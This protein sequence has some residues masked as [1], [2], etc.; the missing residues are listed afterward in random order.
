MTDPKTITIP[1]ELFEELT[2]Y[3][4]TL[5]SE[6]SWKCA[7]PS[8]GNLRI[9]SSYDLLNQCCEQAVKLRDAHQQEQP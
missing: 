7:V 8:R 1:Y 9:T 4:L 2:D 5:R 6:W 3:A